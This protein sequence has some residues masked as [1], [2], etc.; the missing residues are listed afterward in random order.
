MVI[1][2]RYENGNVKEICSE[3]KKVVRPQ[4]LTVNM[5]GQ[6]IGEE[7]VEED[8]L[9]MVVGLLYWDQKGLEKCLDIYIKMLFIIFYNYSVLLVIHALTSVAGSSQRMEWPKMR[10]LELPSDIQLKTNFA[11]LRPP[12]IIP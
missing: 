4:E 5:L 11:N 9:A 6:V 1:D 7:I 8:L 3:S 12:P 2:A 10:L